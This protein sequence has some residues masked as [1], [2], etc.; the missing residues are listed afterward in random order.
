MSELANLIKS[1]QVEVKQSEITYVYYNTEDGKV[2]RLS[3][4]EQVLDND[5]DVLA[6][7]HDIASPIL[8]GE[9]R[10]SDYI[11]IYDIVL[12]QKVLK[13]ITYEDSHK[14]AST[15]CYQLPIIKN[16]RSGHT[17]CTEI[18]DGVEVYIWFKDT[19]YKKD[20]LVWHEDTV[21][22]LLKSNRKGQNFSKKNSLVFIEDVQLT[23]LPTQSLALTTLQYTQEYVG[24]HIDIWYNELEHLAG[25]HVWIGKCVYRIIED[26]SA[27]TEFNPNN[28]EMI[29]SNVLLYK[30]KNK[31]LDT[32]THIQDGDIFLDY[33]KIYSASLVETEYDKTSNDVIF[34]TDQ[35]HIVKWVTQNDTLLRFDTTDTKDYTLTENTIEVVDQTKLKNG[36]IILLGKKLYTIQLDKEY[37]I[38]VTQDKPSK[39]WTLALNP[40]T[41]KYLQMT[42]YDHDDVLYFSITSKHDPNILYRSLKVAMS[43]LNKIHIIPFQHDD[44][45]TQDVSLYTAKYFDSYAH[46]VIE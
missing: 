8:T 6:V 19:A 17:A 40:A 15:M 13:E 27:R 7:P 18:Y 28:A 29:V 44:E 32:I 36:T 12:K 43:Q 31:S 24:L 46:E 14:E 23:N 41:L 38:I 11:V 39:L 33:N 3:G 9:K 1:L 2:N 20:H 45:I 16:N 34:Y 10:T 5:E 30:D 35:H 26:Q 22:K 4:T 42:N 25:Q 37:D 21:Y